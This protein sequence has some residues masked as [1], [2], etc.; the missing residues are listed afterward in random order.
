MA[1]PIAVAVHFQ[2]MNM[3]GQTIEYGT[4]EA[5]GAEDFSPFIEWQVGRDDDR[6]ALV[7]LGDDFKQQLRA[8]FAQ[9]NKAKLVNDQ[10]VLTD[11]QLLQALQTPVIGGLDQFMNERSG[12]REANLH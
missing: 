3:V 4:D 6:A 7:A 2:D 10:Y 11:Q 12:S 8:G 5:L 9:W 1:Q